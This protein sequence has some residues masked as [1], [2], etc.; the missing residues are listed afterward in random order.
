MWHLRTLSKE[1]AMKIA[2]IIV[3]FVLI[4]AVDTYEKL[5]KKKHGGM[6]GSEN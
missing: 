3:V 4:L 5:D 1:D 6:K 2:A